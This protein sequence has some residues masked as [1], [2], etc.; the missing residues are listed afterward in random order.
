MIESNW[1]STAATCSWALRWWASFGALTVNTPS[2]QP[3]A[4]T[5]LNTALANA[6]KPDTT[7]AHWLTSC[8]SDNGPAFGAATATFA[9]P[10]SCTLPVVALIGA[11]RTIGVL[12]SRVMPASRRSMRAINDAL[13]LALLILVSLTSAT[14]INSRASGAWRISI[15]ISPS[16]SMART[17]VLAPMRRAWSAIWVLRSSG[18]CTKSG[19]INDK[20]H[21]RSWRT[22]SSANIRGSA[23]RW[24]AVAVAPSARPG[25]LSIMASTNSSGESCSSAS[26]PPAATSSSADSVSRAEPPPC[27]S[28]CAIAASLTLRLASFITHRTCSSRSCIGNKWNCKCWVRLRIVSLTF[29]GSVVASTNT[30]WGGGSSSVLSNAASAGFDSMC[31]SSKIKTRCRPGLPSDERSI[32]SRMFSTPLLLAAS[33]SRTS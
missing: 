9:L 7:S 29:C 32:R 16:T 5:A 20:K 1:A 22:I 2:A 14:S 13:S 26:P 31:T 18:N 25:S 10:P 30:T 11:G 6:L 3:T 33:S 27:V 8:S 21:S 17:T 28:T 4:L 12:A 19:A 24:I 15:K 23:P